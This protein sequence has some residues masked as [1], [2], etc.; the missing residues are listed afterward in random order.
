MV[1]SSL[2]FVYFFLAI[3]LAAYFFCKTIKSKNIVLV[4]ASLVFYA[5]GEPIWVGL[6]VLSAFINWKG[7]LLIEKYKN[8]RMATLVAGLAIFID[9]AFLIIFKYSGFIVENINGLF[10][11]SIPVPQIQMPIGISFF[12]FQA[13]SY[14]LDVMWET[15]PAQKKY[16]R[17]LL[18]L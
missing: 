6:L 17:F 2:F 13:I 11:S 4:V 5:W 15:V 9:L 16:P 10:H 18:Y 1:F 3:T 12:T 7:A 14:I 8:T